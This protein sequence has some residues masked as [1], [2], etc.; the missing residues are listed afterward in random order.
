MN[1]HG[2]SDGRV[3]PTKSPNKGREQKKRGYGQPYTGTKAETP[4]TDKGKPTAVAT[5]AHQ[6]AEGMEGR[7]PAEGNL[8][9][10]TML[11]TQRRVRMQQELERVRQAAKKDKGL[12]FTALLHHV[13]LVDRLREAYLRLK[14]SASP[15]IDGQTWQQYGKELEANLQN[16]SE[17][18]KRGAYRA[19]PVRR[20]YIR[21][22]DGGQRP[23]GIPTLEDKIVQGAMTAVL[24]AIYEVDFLGFSYGFRPGRSQ[25]MAL[26][27][28]SV[29][30]GRERVRW[31]LDADIRGFFATIDH[32]WLIK[33][34]EHRIGDQRVTCLIQKWLKAGVLEDGEQ[35][36]SE[37]GTPQG[38]S[39]SPLLANIYLHYVFDL[40]AHQW[41]RKHCR[42]RVSM[43]RYADDIVL[44]F[45]RHQEAE[46][47][48]QALG[49]RFA[50]FGLKLHPEKTRLIEFG[51]FA[52]ENRRQRGQGKPETFNF[53]GFTHFCGQNRDGRFRVG[54][55][56]MAKR[57]RAKLAEIKV[58]L[59]RRRHV[60]V[61]RV[62][63]WLQSVLR[64]HDWYYGVPFNYAALQRFRWNVKVLWRRTLARRSQKGCMT[65]ARM[66]RIAKRWLPPATIHHPYSSVRFDART[67]GRSRVR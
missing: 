45:E 54:R 6:P 5:D 18:L 58:E 30:I 49:Q 35:R 57:M 16:L 63:V 29:A 21:K 2:K 10:Q 47:F 59:K 61:P 66:D 19:K 36:R 13:Y 20:A 8:R 60:P 46:Q 52:R 51:L 3:V 32:G 37:E 7:R 43:V 64:G 50:N 39:I 22:A 62:G 27:A 23:L 11:R 53:L 15:G 12:R 41:R 28:L 24:N 14:R 4:E 67:Q 48:L 25:H 31:V 26:D 44:G 9:Q 38:G 17:R 34:V 40:W 33:F 56:T 55:R 1:G 65:W 42:G